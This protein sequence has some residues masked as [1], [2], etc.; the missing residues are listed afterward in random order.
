MSEVDYSLKDSRTGANSHRE[1]KT[2]SK[3]PTWGQADTYATPS[4]RGLITG[5]FLASEK[6]KAA[7]LF[8]TEPNTQFRAAVFRDFYPTMPGRRPCEAHWTAPEAS[9][10]YIPPPKQQPT[11]WTLLFKITSAYSLSVE[12]RT[13][14]YKLWYV[15]STHLKWAHPC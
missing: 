2:A 15:H 7:Q 13:Y 10:N 3:T 8:S 14:A 11:Q 9:A 1:K 4:W 12:P 6:K 5:L